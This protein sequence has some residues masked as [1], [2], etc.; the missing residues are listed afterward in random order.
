VEALMVL[1]TIDRDGCTG[2]G[3]C[4]EVCHSNALGL[5]NLR[6]IVANAGLCDYCS[7]CEAICPVGAIRCPFEVVC[8]EEA[9]LRGRPV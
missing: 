4:V 8:D 2:C 7:D 9:A 6:A 3:D 5:R 1:P